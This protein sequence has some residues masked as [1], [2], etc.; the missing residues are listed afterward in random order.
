M[1]WFQQNRWLGTFL[2]AFG[3]CALLALWFLFH[4]KG[5]FDEA[6]ARFDETAT[7]RNR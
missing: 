7:E 5:N 2:I 1:N 4:A 6:K 3:V